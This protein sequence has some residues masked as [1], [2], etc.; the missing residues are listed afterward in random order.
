MSGA[1]GT[2]TNA[3][4]A[5]VDARIAATEGDRRALAYRDKVYSFHDFAA[6][7]NRAGNMLRGLGVERGGRVIVML[8]PSPVLFGLILGAMKI[9]AAAVIIEGPADA[10]A[11]RSA[12]EAHA[13]A[14][15]IVDGTRLDGIRA[16]LS[17]AQIIVAGDP[18]ERLPSLIEMLRAAPSSLAAEEVEGEA[19]ALIVR[20]GSDELSATHAQLITAAKENSASSLHLGSMDLSAALAAP[21]GDQRSCSFWLLAFPNAAL[22]RTE[23]SRSL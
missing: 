6:L 16:G 20:D 18:R 2:W 8:P 9:D 1:A 14:A 23:R 4:A 5:I 10:V 13:P 11:V 22:G 19:T 12:R 3:A 21:A 17:G 7:M 15:V